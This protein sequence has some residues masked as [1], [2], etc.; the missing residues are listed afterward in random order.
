[1][2]KRVCFDQ[3]PHIHVRINLRGV[4]AGVS[5]EGLNDTKVYTSF[6]Q[7]CGEAVSKCV[8][9]NVF[10]YFRFDHSLTQDFP[11]A[12]PAHLSAAVV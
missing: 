5:Q 7:M 3:T 1:M 11:K 2:V 8:R 10:V 9:G 6:Q 12:H 4:D